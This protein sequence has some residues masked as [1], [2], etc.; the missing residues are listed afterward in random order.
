MSNLAEGGYGE[1]LLQLKQRIRSAQ[2]RAS[3]S[4]NRELVLLFWQIGRDILERQQAQGWGAKVIDQLAHDLT[5]AF[6]DIK[7]FFRRNLLYM[8]SFAEQWPDLEFVQQAVAQIPLGHNIPIITKC[9]SV[10]EASFY[11][12]QTLEQG[13][14]R[15]I[16]ALQ[17]KSGLYAR[18]GKVPLNEHNVARQLSQHITQ[19]WLELG[20]ALA[21]I[22]RQ[23]HL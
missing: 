1:W 5:A 23:Y 17:L 11:I 8:R 6:P 14:S 16:L 10:A 22:G 13:W 12:D 4:V 2:Q 18:T 20:K 3:L 9:S 19:F 21:F 7:G 15:D